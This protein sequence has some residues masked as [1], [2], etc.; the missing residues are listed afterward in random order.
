M[1]LTK[2]AIKKV[3]VDQRRHAVNLVR[4]SRLRTLLKKATVEATFEAVSAAYAALDKAVKVN[5]VHR[6]YANRH[7]SQ[8]SKLAKPTKFQVSAKASASKAPVKKTL[9]KTNIKATAAKI[10]AAKTSSKKT[11]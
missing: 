2:S 3:R 10:P 5:M 8:L 6:N 1:P 11:P 4:L 7:K 9:A